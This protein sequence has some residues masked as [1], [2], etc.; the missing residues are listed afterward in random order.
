M[1]LSSS[2]KFFKTLQPIR[3]TCA[4]VLIPNSEPFP[5]PAFKTNTDTE[6]KSQGR[7]LASVPAPASQLLTV[8]A[9]TDTTHTLL[10]KTQSALTF[11]HNPQ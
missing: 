11:K 7:Q 4:V 3:L 1:I 5:K 10:H 6:T 9:Q 2:I 8:T